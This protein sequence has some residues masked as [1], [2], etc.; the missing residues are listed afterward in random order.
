MDFP[1][2]PLL[3]YNLQSSVSLSK[4]RSPKTSPTIFN[5]L[6]RR[7]KNTRPDKTLNLLSATADA[8][9]TAP[10]LMKSRGRAFH[11]FIGLFGSIARGHL[12]NR[13]QLRIATKI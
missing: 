12:N 6:L 4:A 11:V 3:I 1:R 8:P 5:Q 7:Q 9:N 10:E 2:F 13:Q